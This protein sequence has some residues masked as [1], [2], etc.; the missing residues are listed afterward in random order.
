[1][2]VGQNAHKQG[3]NVTWKKKK[4]VLLEQSDNG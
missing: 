2:I 3:V 4:L 1:M